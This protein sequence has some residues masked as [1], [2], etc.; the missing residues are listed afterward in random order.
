MANHK[1]GKLLDFMS[2]VLKDIIDYDVKNETN[3]LNILICYIYN[4]CNTNNT[5]RDIYFAK[6][7]L[8]N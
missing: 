7:I 8:H 5:A 2:K 1:S 3:Y 6:N 4:N